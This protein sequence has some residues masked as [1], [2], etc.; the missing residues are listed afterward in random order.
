M[1]KQLL[2]IGVSIGVSFAILALLLNLVTSGIADQERPSVFAALQ[3][4]SLGLVLVYFVLYLITL[5]VRAHRYRLLIAM[6]GEQNVPTLRQMALVT[7]I[8][9]MVVDMLPAR[10]G[11]LG[12][13]GLLNRGYGVKLQHCISSLTVSIALDF[14]ALLVVVVLIIGKQIAGSGIQG[15]AIGALISALV[16]ATL[17]VVG[18]FVITPFANKWLNSR[19]PPRNENGLWSKALKLLGEFSQSLASVRSSG[20][21]TQ[22]VV[23][24]ILIRILKYLGMYLL[25]RAVAAPSFPNLAELP[26]EHVVSALVGGEIGASL[27]IPT[28]MSFGAY[29]AGGAL[30]FQL[31]GV[32]NQAAGVVTMLCIHIWS[33]FMEYVLGGILL[34]VF[35]L[36]RRRGEQL[37]TSSESPK[38]AGLIRAA[39]FAGA[40][41]VM[42][43]GSFFFAYQLWAASKLGSL[44]APAAGAVAEDQQEWRQLSKQHVSNL[45]GFVVFS[46]NRDGNHDI[47][48]LDLASFEVSK[49]TTHE[50]T[51]TYPRIS[52]DGKRLVFARAHQPWVS[53][54]NTVAWDVYVLDLASKQEIKVGSDGTAPAWISDNEITYSQQATKVVKVNVDSGQAEVLYESGVNNAMPPN[55]QLQ[56]PKYNPLTKQFVFTGRQNQIGMNT[57]HW[58][59]AL[60]NGDTH[61]GVHDGCELSW[62]SAGTELFQVT[63]GGRNE[64][65]RIGS[66]DPET[67]ALTTLIDLDGEFIHEY[68]PKESSNGEYMVFG[69][70]RSAKEHEH[71]T[72]DYEIFLW[73]VGSKPSEATRLTFHTG[74]D[75][76]PDVYVR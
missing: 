38:R 1:I 58:G 22:V 72:A 67:L 30:V 14:I 69:A 42:L 47:F 33:Q 32:V 6:S 43:A 66:V 56:N 20:H 52:P 62:N 39:S 41:A 17:A 9:N 12:Y 65:L 4:T 27:P 25:F 46:S 68:W 59:T 2:R 45:D 73:K 71:D 5:F 24:S 40:G 15:W 36:L 37:A 76:W 11:E 54:R 63:R 18:L 61:R 23:L 3:A 19:F 28:F 50:H 7:G 8:R 31:L 64:T 70:S 34:A 75:N 13:V 44:S 57:G 10:L 49:L 16:L 26:V 35:I 21:T 53:Q 74:N 48:Q 51:E 60:S 55:S 29:E